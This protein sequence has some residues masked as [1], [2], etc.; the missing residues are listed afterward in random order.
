[1]NSVWCVL[2]KLYS[3]VLHFENARDKYI[4]QKIAIFSGRQ[5]DAKQ[6]QCFV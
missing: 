6:Q 4:H 3:T 2:K 1:M 5:V